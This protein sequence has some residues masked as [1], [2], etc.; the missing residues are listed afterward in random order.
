METSTRTIATST[1][2]VGNPI[3]TAA[4]VAVGPLAAGSYPVRSPDTV[5]PAAADRWSHGLH[6][7]TVLWIAL[8][9]LGTLPALFVFTWK[10]LLLFLVLSWLTGG[11]GVCLGYHRLMAHFSF[12]T[13]PFVRRVLALL[14]ALAGQGPP[15]TWI[16]VHRKH[17]QY[18]D[19]AGD[20]HSPREGAWWSHVFWLFPRPHEPEWTK[21]IGRYSKD[22]L[23]DPFMRLLDKT[24]ILWHL[25]LGAALFAAGWLGWGFFTGLSF[26]VYGMFLR[27]V[28]VMHVTW[29]VNSASHM[30]GY[31]NYDTPDDSRNLWWVGLLAYGEG[32]HNNHH[33]FSNCARHGHRWWE[34]DVTYMVICLMEKLGLAWDVVRQRPS[35]GTPS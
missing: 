30:W 1:I 7:S 33:A 34:V 15:V 8:L 4:N 3:N 26:L 32:W 16:G 10:G 25:A 24:Y 21:M 12:Q 20:P 22:L 27:L 9:H 14:G 28:W 11:L 35:Q 2:D 17:H 31:R 5:A 6:W 19:I 13:Y 23:R 29:A 18:T